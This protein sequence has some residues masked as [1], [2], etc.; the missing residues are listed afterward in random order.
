MKIAI[1]P[2]LVTG[3][4]RSGTTWVGQTIAFHKAVTFIQEPFNVDFPCPDFRYQFKTWF[5]YV[6]EM[7][8]EYRVCSSFEKLLNKISNPYLRAQQ[9]TLVKDP[10]ALM[11]AGWL[12]EK[13]DF[14]VICTIR[15]PLAFVGSLKKWNWYFDFEQFL[16]QEYLIKIKLSHFEAKIKEFCKTEH[17]IIDQSC[18]LWNILHFVIWE[19]KNCYPEWLY[20]RHEDL[21]IE[22]L[23]NFQ[24]IFAYL[25]LDLSKE[26]SLLIQDYTADV[27]S[28]ET[29]DTSFKPRNARGSLDTWQH[30]LTAT[31]IERVIEQ[32]KDIAKEFYL[33]D[34][35]GSE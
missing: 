6:P 2:I 30:R 4:H 17:D 31:E 26:I 7:Q 14:R 33:G 28:S 10:L 34:I 22:P 27:H 32:T 23:K 13:L 20:V 3:A 5:Q 9:I 12:Y 15:N 1:N 16:K 24:K 25:N 21:A 8:D 29:D 18:L 11:S 19:Y 35:R